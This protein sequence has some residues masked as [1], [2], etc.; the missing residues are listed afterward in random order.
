M[1]TPYRKLQQRCKA[2]GLP[3]NRSAAVLAGLLADE[4]GR[5]HGDAEVAGTG[6]GA[7]TTRSL[8]KG[9]SAG[10]GSGSVEQDRRVWTLQWS[11][12]DWVLLGCIGLLGADLLHSPSMADPTKVHTRTSY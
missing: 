4:P 11:W 8:H 7:C 6:R 12:M 9:V 2:A 3:A 10:H 1:A 5:G